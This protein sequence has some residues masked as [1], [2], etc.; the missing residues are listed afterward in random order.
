[1]VFLSSR[2][3]L[4]SIKQASN[5]VKFCA[6]TSKFTV[7]YEKSTSKD[8]TIMI[9]LKERAMMIMLTILLNVMMPVA[10]RI[11]WMRRRIPQFQHS[12]KIT[13]TVQEISGCMHHEI[14]L[15]ISI[16]IC[17]YVFTYM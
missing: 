1:M 4:H 2:T 8:S 5:L 12:L 9:C 6:I 3:G 13:T 17:M 10:L 16:G 11:G 15:S 7:I 14:Y